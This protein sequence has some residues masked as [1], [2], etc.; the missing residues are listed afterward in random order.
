MS[1]SPARPKRGA[2]LVPLSWGDLFDK[3]TI[4]EIKAQRLTAPQALDN[5]K[6]ELAALAQVVETLG[7]QPD[8]LAALKAELKAMNEKLWDIENGT[9]AKEAAKTFDQE[10]ISLTR[11]V[12]LNNDQRARIK[13]AINELLD[14]EIVE[15][16]QYTSYSS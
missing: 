7:V 12:Y 14:S 9:R 16:K 5:V 6:R 8:K 11:S 2:P 4:L 1:N 10:F 13:R 15:E 3:L